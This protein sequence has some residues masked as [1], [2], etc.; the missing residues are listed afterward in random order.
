MGSIGYT[1][2]P[3]TN[4]GLTFVSTVHHDT[5]PTIDASKVDMVGRH[6]FITGASRGIGQALAVAYAVAG[7]S[8]IGIA[9]RSD[10]SSVKE[11]VEAAALATGRKL[12]KVIT[13]PLDISDKANIEEALH[14]LGPAFDF[15]LD[16]LVNNAGRMETWKPL[17]ETDFDDWW[18]SW[19]VNVRGTSLVT[20][21]LLPLLLAAGSLKTVVNVSSIGALMTSAGGSAYQCN[22]FAVLRLTEFLN[23]EYGDSQGLLAFS[24]HPGMVE[25]PLSL[26]LPKFLHS[27]LKDTPELMAN[28]T[29]Y[30]THQRQEW[31]AGRYISCNWDMEE[32]L[33]RKEEIVSLDKLKM[34]LMV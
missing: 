26:N 12:P 27:K 21:A 31:L 9:A 13:V 34:K 15:K 23:V 24:M 5:Y 1:A 33:S 25:T 8:I 2:Q 19:E 29:V 11:E 3:S 16:V 30:L 18:S 10:L 6:V 7:A 4:G 28:T 17:G 20:R 22:K 32:F 14:D